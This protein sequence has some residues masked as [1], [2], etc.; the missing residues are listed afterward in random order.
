MRARAL[1][2]GI[3]TAVAA[4][5]PATALAATTDGAAVSGEVYLDLDGDGTRDA[6][7]PGRASV[8]LTLRTDATILDA[9]VTDADG[10][11]VFNNVPTGPLTLVVE[12]P[13]DHVITGTTVPGLSTASGEADVD[14]TGDVDLGT[15]GLGSPVVSG[16]DVATTVAIDEDASTDDQFTWVLSTL[17]LGPDTAAGPVDLRAVL[18]AGHEVL[19]ATG[20]GW[21][22]ELSTAIVLC[23][24]ASDLAAGT[25]LPPVSLTTAAT[26]DVGTTVTVT[27]TVRLDGVFDGAPLNDEDVASFTIGAELAA[28]DIDGDGTGDLTTAGAPASGLLVAA[29]L[30]L[31]A[32]AS[33]VTTTRRTRRP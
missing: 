7:E 5:V 21:D 10:R 12:P 18:S 2:I 6:G 32:G 8:Q 22:C 1:A 23:S 14:V 26:G 24:T 9:A 25:I 28:D 31:V 17:N 4:L 19:D 13:N 27:G 33:V 11:W 30:A 29:V 3:A 20:D 15:V 16:A